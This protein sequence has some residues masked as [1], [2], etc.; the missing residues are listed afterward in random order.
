[1]SANNTKRT[2][3]PRDDTPGAATVLWKRR[4]TIFVVTALV[5]AVAVVLS[6]RMTPVF[7]SNASVLVESAPNQTVNNEPNMATEKQVATSTSVARIVMG[8]LHL[9]QS[10]QTLLQ[11]LSVSV[12]VDTQILDISYSDPQPR[13]AQQRAQAFA[14]AYIS[15]RQQDLLAQLST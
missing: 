13:I 7:A 12:P 5:V 2:D 10:A 9:T 14:D 1:M 11:H 15:Y 3:S 4:W 8:K 6:V